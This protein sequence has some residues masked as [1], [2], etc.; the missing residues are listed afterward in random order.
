MACLAALSTIVLWLEAAG[1]MIAMHHF[2][3]AGAVAVLA[4]GGLLVRAIAVP[5]ATAAEPAHWPREDDAARVQVVYLALLVLAYV[6]GSLLLQR[7]IALYR[8]LERMHWLYFGF[9][10][11]LM[12]TF[13]AW[14]ALTE[15]GVR[16]APRRW[17]PAIRSSAAALPAAFVLVHAADQAGAMLGDG[18][19]MLS[20]MGVGRSALDSYARDPIRSIRTTTTEAIFAMDGEK[21]AAAPLARPA[22]LRDGDVTLSIAPTYW[23]YRMRPHLYAIMKQAGYYREIYSES[24]A[25][26]QL[27][28]AFLPS[29][30]AYNDAM[31][32]R[33]S[34]L[35]LSWLRRRGVTVIVDGDAAFIAALQEQWPHEIEKIDTDT[36]RIADPG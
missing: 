6:A 23:H 31:D 15:I 30:Y 34:A 35:L 27:G 14:R 21:G 28:E 33:V 36:Y 4:V 20:R 25:L 9:F 12:A 11:F 32:G 17:L 8:G 16:C 2:F 29:F 19:S 3:V 5:G 22:W 10:P 18:P 1:E 7:E 24:F 26:E 13:Y